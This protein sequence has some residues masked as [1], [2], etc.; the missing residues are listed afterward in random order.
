MLFSILQSNNCSLVNL[1]PKKLIERHEEA[2]VSI[3]FSVVLKELSMV[4]Y[5]L[6]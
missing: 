4:L 5:R 6:P 3:R 1:S 2:Q